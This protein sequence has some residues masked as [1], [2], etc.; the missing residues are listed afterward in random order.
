M[1]FG[2]LL[3]GARFTGYLFT[4]LRRPLL[5]ASNASCHCF[6]IV[7]EE[8]AG[9]QAGLYNR[10]HVSNIVYLEA[11]SGMPIWLAS[12]MVREEGSATHKDDRGD[13]GISA[14]RTTCGKLTRHQEHALWPNARRSLI[15]SAPPPR[16]TWQVSLRPWRSSFHR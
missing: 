4:T 13:A 14:V 8:R 7:F 11:R 3:A 9:R 15:R 12:L 16:C 5:V 2:D 10:P 1:E 6:R